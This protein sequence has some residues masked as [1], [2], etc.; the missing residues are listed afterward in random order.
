MSLR[1]YKETIRRLSLQIIQLQKP[2]RIL[3]AIKW[4]PSIEKKIIQ[5]RYRSLPQVNKAT[6]A[7]TKL[8][9]STQKTKNAFKDIIGRISLELGPSDEVGLL[10]SII[11]QEYI[12]AIRLLEHRGTKE[13]WRI[14]KKLY[15]SPK[16]SFHDEKTT[17]LH[18]GE[19]LY[20]ILSRMGH[21]EE[22]ET[23]QLSAKQVVEDL[24]S[25]FKKYFRDFGVHA[26]LD[27]AIIT[28]ASAGSDLVKIRKN[29]SFSKNA[30]DLL[31]VHEG[32]VHIGTTQNG[33][34]QPF[35]KWLSKGPPR[36]VST[37]EG[38]AVLMELVSF[39]S[40]VDRARKINN[41][42]LAIDKA[43][44]G[45]NALDI[46]EFFRTEG[47]SEEE[48]L[49]ATQRVFR[50]TD[51]RGGSAFTK[52]IAYCKGFVQN[53][54]FMQAAIRSGLPRLIP[55]LFVG[56]IHLDDIP[57]LYRLHREGIVERPKY[58][59]PQF[60]DINGLAVW[61]SFS[62][63]LNRIS[64]DRVQRHYNALFKKHL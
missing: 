63:F 53:Y 12:D 26:K 30:V 45:A 33:M 10:L 23:T 52:D 28:D 40:H 9:F 2:I 61:L 47:Y 60:L 55:F 14:S 22:E 21:L 31:E 35:A 24:N 64:L 54:N 27:D 39:K 36:C 19:T 32:W 25:R 37:Q 50:G 58:L 5:S 48:S 4:H 34:T 29:A 46:I 44:N 51:L 16:D 1:D 6:Y 38:L 11:C 13:F 18:L 17:V 41:R 20:S 57:L 3:D 62:N 42:I 15:G 49:L 56:K 59:P 8:G 43:E 7:K